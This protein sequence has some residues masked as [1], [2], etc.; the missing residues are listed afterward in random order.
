MQNHNCKTKLYCVKLGFWLI[1]FFFAQSWVEFIVDVTKCQE[2]MFVIV[3][4]LNEVVLEPI[5][6]GSKLL[7]FDLMHVLGFS[8]CVSF[9][10]Y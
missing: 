10:K 7:M 5:K 8:V 3:F 2:D 1:L 9:I 6:S 4:F